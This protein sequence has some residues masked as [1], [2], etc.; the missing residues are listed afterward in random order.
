MLTPDQFKVNEAWLAVRINE[1]FLF[2]TELRRAG[3]SM[4]NLGVALVKDE[5]NFIDHSKSSAFTVREHEL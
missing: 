5:G 3:Y 4:H 1:E 2:A